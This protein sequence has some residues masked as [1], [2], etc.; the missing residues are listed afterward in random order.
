MEYSYFSRF[1]EVRYRHVNTLITL[2]PLCRTFRRI[3]RQDTHTAVVNRL[4]ANKRASTPPS[5]VCTKIMNCTWSFH[6]MKNET[7]KTVY[8]IITKTNYM[9]IREI[10][11]GR[12]MASC[13]D[14]MTHAINRSMYYHVKR[15]HER[16]ILKATHVNTLIIILSYSE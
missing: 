3:L 15:E 2:L 11:E 12:R 1:I 14:V 7:P 9:F 16:I 4:T 10:L 5:S 13:G 6:K 8:G